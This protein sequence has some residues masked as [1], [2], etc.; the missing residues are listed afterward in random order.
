MANRGVALLWGG[1]SCGPSK[2]GMRTPFCTMFLGLYYV[3]VSNGISILTA[4]F[5]AQRCLRLAARAENFL[6]LTLISAAAALPFVSGSG[7]LVA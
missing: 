7:Q 2:V 4:V 6:S 5:F 3:R 1:H